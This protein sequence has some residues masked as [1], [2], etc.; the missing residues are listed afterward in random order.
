M[1]SAR[2]SKH[3]LVPLVFLLIVTN[4]HGADS[5]PQTRSLDSSLQHSATPLNKND[6]LAYFPR[7]FWLRSNIFFKEIRFLKSLLCQIYRDSDGGCP[8]RLGKLQWLSLAANVT[9]PNTNVSRCVQDLNYLLHGLMT[10]ELWA[11]TG[12]NF[13]SSHCSI[14]QYSNNRKLD[15]L[16]CCI[17]LCCCQN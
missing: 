7:D 11:L 8:D 16:K 14:V 3:I 1:T 2:T 13:S 9:P 4:S 10:G 17:V 15:C 6:S 5:T 12:R